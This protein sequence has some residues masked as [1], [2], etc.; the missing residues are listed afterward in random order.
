MSDFTWQ[1]KVGFGRYA[2]LTIEYVHANYHWY[3]VWCI[4][5][6]DHKEPI[7]EWYKKEVDRVMDKMVEEVEKAFEGG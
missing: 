4:D 7:I 2:H 1:S 6:M 3:I 5:D